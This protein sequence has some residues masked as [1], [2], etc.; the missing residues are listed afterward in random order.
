[1]N[2]NSNDDYDKIEMNNNRQ[3]KF[4]NLAENM[5]YRHPYQ[6]QQMNGYNEY[7][8]FFLYLILF[9]SFLNLLELKVIL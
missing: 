2:N 8:F 3:N 5:I 4:S 7:F 6:P 1:V 9:L